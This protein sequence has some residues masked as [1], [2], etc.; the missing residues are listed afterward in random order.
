[1]LEGTFDG[2]KA[3]VLQHEMDHF[4]FFL[5]LNYGICGNQIEWTRTVPNSALLEKMKVHQ[6]EIDASK[7]VL[8]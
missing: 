3:R 8:D 5:I 4:L 1:V 6:Q 2:F 7:K